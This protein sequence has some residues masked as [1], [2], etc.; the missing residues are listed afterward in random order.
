MVRAA[1]GKR[2]EEKPE[3]KAKEAK[4]QVTDSSARLDGEEMVYNPDAAGSGIDRTRRRDSAEDRAAVEE[5]K[6][7]KQQEEEVETRVEGG[8][9]KKL[10]VGE[11]TIGALFS[12]VDDPKEDVEIWDEE[13][14]IDEDYQGHHEEEETN[15]EK[16]PITDEERYEGMEKELAKMDQ[17]KT[18]K[19]VPKDEVKGPIL[20]STW[21]EARKPDG[22]VRMRYCLREFK[23]STYRDDVYAVS[24][25]SATGRLIDLVGVSKQHVSS[26]RMRPMHSGKFPKR[27]NATCTRRNNGWQKRK[28]LE[29]EQ[30]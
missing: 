10:K 21:V 14:E 15:W 13:I 25:T 12:A 26:Q 24:T 3:E 29:G 16:V 9:S 1:P 27:R 18:Y 11:Q 23:S 4:V 30:V 22:P 5:V 28:Q 19:P 20:D 7:W 8:P 17:F 2:S 6:R